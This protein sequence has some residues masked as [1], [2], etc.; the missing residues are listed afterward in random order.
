MAGEGAR[1]FGRE[2]GVSVS[3][4]AL[5]AL[6]GFIN[7]IVLARW[8]GPEGRG[9]YAI[10]V[11]AGA[12][13]LPLALVGMAETTVVAIGRGF[14]PEQLRTLHRRAV[15]FSLPLSLGTAALLFWGAGERVLS[16]PTIAL[17]AALLA[18]PA[19]LFVECARA[20]WLAT[21]RVLAY[22]L[23]GGVS[24][25]ALLAL[26]GLAMGGREEWVL[27]NFVLAYALAAFA[28]FWARERRSRQLPDP[29]LQRFARGYGPRAALNAWGE[30]AATR[31]DYLLL[32]PMLPLQELGLYALADQLAQLCTW[33]S[34][35]AGKLLLG[36]SARDPA[37][38]RRLL[39]SCT[40]LTILAFA[41]LGLGVLTAGPS[42]VTAL[43]GEAFAPSHQAWLWLLPFAF[44]RALSA[45]Y[46]NDLL[47]KGGA[48]AVAVS[49]AAGLAAGLAVLLP[50][51]GLC[52]WMGAGLARSLGAAV[53]FVCL[54]GL[55]RRFEQ[56]AREPDLRL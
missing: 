51:L 8:V 27:V 39:V 19:R 35:Q 14:A 9:L 38:G 6:C 29:R 32:A 1:R 15:V 24:A 49:G 2:L 13:M 52:G 41:G 7:N 17:V 22:A 43:F 18:L 20:E 25:F 50:A 36:E 47:A 10:A 37:S 3:M 42:L 26:N 55:R 30:A 44:F 46:A 34:V 4:V 56:G 11:S 45:L 33:V 54:L 28:V 5:V 40:R 31:L 21:R 16:L 23:A 48:G 53:G 12:L